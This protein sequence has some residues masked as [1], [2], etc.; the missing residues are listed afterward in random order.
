M[1]KSFSRNISGKRLVYFWYP[2]ASFKQIIG[3]SDHEEKT[4]FTK[5][6]NSVNETSGTCQKFQQISN[7]WLNNHNK[8]FFIR[9]LFMNFTK[10]IITYRSYNCRHF[11]FVRNLRYKVTTITPRAV[12]SLAVLPWKKD[13][14]HQRGVIKSHGRTHRIPVLEWPRDDYLHYWI[15]AFLRR[16][17]YYISLFSV[18]ISIKNTCC[19]HFRFPVITLS[20]EWNILWEVLSGLNA[21]CDNVLYER[22]IDILTSRILLPVRL[23]FLITIF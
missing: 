16:R 23:S 9:N 22:W 21:R 2:F 17:R 14:S 3:V 11:T 8:F 12:F 20:H 7:W 5:L 13:S 1:A 19:S 15:I 4:I 10:K 6:G 18:Y